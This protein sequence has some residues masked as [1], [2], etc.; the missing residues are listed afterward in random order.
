MVWRDNPTPYNVWISEI[1]LQQTR[2]EA[3]KGYFNRFTE[4]LP[5]IESLAAVSEDKLLKLWEGLGYYNRARNLQKTAKILVEQYDSQMP[6]EYDVLL[7]LPG[8][9]PYTAG[10]ISSIAFNEKAPAVDGN[11]LRVVMRYL[12]REDDISKMKIR[13]QVEQ[14]LLSVMP[15]EAGEFNQAIMELGE[16]VCIPNGAPLCDR[17]PLQDTC[18]GYLGKEPQRY[19]NKPEKKPR[20]LVDYTVLLLEWKGKYGIRKRP[21]SGLLASLWEFPMLEFVLSAEQIKEHFENKGIML[22]RI[23]KAGKSKHI[24]SHVEWHMTGY[25][26]VISEDTPDEALLE[27]VL[28]LS[29]EEIIHQYSIPTAFQYFLKKL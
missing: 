29:T 1:M 26:V 20:R 14:S 24:F 5:D 13:R 17:C 11:V 16:V 23:T 9:G 15:D 19:P 18:T 2:I 28:F 7:T 22:N 12:A 10:A 8:V 27:D 25:H 4:A 21:E 3:A 6:R